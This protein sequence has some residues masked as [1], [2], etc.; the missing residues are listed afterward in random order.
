MMITTIQMAMTPIPN[1]TD[2]PPAATVSSNNINKSE[3]MTAATEG[4]TSC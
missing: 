1:G 2:H 4:I 3:E